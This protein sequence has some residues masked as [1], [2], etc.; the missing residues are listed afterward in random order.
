MSLR[1]KDSPTNKIHQIRISQTNMRQNW[2]PTIFSIDTEKII[3]WY[4]VV[5]SWETFWKHK[6]EKEIAFTLYRWFILNLP[7]TWCSSI[8]ICFLHPWVL[9]TPVLYIYE[10]IFKDSSSQTSGIMPRVPLSKNINNS[11]VCVLYSAFIMNIMFFSFPSKIHLKFTC[12]S[13]SVINYEC[14]LQ[15]QTADMKHKWTFNH[16]L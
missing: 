2:N 13:I 9:T 7:V 16:F 5:L 11:L 8:K 1:C 14:T 3:L 6:Y 12:F 10:Q 15:S 4:S